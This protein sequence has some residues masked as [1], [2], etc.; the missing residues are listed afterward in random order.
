MTV[1]AALRVS[2]DNLGRGAGALPGLRAEELGWDSDPTRNNT[3][4]AANG[5]EPVPHVGRPKTRESVG[6][7]V[8]LCRNS[9]RLDPITAAK[10]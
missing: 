9:G 1:A 3:I 10:L 2:R 7:D 8:L 6:D 4:I 5:G